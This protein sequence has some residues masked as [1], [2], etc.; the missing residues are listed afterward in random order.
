M[1][2]TMNTG[3]VAPLVKEFYPEYYVWNEYPVEE[4]IAFKTVSDRWGVLSNFYSAPLV[5]EGVEF[6][7]SEQ[8]FQMMK[9]TDRQTL[10]AIY[11]AKGL[12]LKWAAKKGEKEGLCRPDWGRIIIDCMK[13]C[14]QTKYDQCEDFRNALIETGGFHIVEDQTNEKTIRRGKADTWGVLRTGD[15]YTGSNLMGRLLMEMRGKGKLD[16]HLPEDIF[17]FIRQ[18]EP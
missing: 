9:F 1:T 10:M 7:N 8:L 2:S 6:V 11:R 18:L 17:G 5:V 12:P 14:L 4:C 3:K 16:Y 15:K 13:F